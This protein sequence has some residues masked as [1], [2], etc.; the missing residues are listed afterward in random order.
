MTG[1][2]SLE[3]GLLW[4]LGFVLAAAFAVVAGWLWLHLGHI[5]TENPRPVVHQVMAEFFRDVAWTMPV[6]LVLALAFTALTLRRS[7]APLRE[8]SAR[9]STIRP[10]ALD[11][12]LPEAGLPTEIVPLVRATNEMLDRV[13]AG[14]AVQRRFTANAA[15]ELR[16]PLQ[17]LASGLESL[18]PAPAVD[19]LREDVGRMSRLVAQLLAVARLDARTETVAGTADIARVA[20]ETLTMLAPI[21]IA[22]GVTVAL[23]RTPGPVLVRGDFT[24]LGDLVRNLAENAIAHAPAGTEVTVVVHPDGRLDVVDRGPGIAPE[25]RQRAFERF[26]RAPGAPPGGTGLGLAIVKEIADACGATLAIEDTAGAGA[27][28]TVRFAHA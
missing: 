11:Q 19:A 10:G 15:H 22:R 6:V 27:T 28:L 14:F 25:H 17:L 18:G 13:E 2:R 23:D 21:A 20:A 1:G 5:E 4:R 8:V 16:T 12:R 26:W 3:T 7:L 24:L 9:A